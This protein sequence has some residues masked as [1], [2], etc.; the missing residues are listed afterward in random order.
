MKRILLTLVVLAQVLFVSARPTFNI[1]DFGAKGNGKSLNTEAINRAITTCSE[2]GGGVVVVP[3]GEYLCGTIV[4][5]DNV[6]L[7]LEEGSR[8]VATTDLASYKGYVCKR[9]DF[10]RYKMA[11][12]EY[13][14]KAFVL[15]VGKQNFAITG[16][17]T[18]CGQHVEN[19]NGEER[20]RGPH[21]IVFAE[22]KNFTISGIHVDKAGNY[23]FMGYEL[24]NG[25]YDNLRITEGYDGIHIR[26]GKN[27][28]I[29][30]CKIESGDDA[31]AGG[32]WENFVI[33]N[34]DL[35]TTI[36]GVRL[37]YPATGLE[38]G[39]CVFKG[40]GVYPQRSVRSLRG[41]KLMM[42]AVILQ[43]GAWQ[44]C[45]GVLKDI[46]IHDLTIDNLR[47]AFCSDLKSGT[48]AENIVLERIKATNIYHSALQFVGY[49]GGTH[50]SVTLRDVDIEYV[51]RIDD[52]VQNPVVK[53]THIEAHVYPYWGLYLK[54]IK[55]CTLENVKLSYT[56]KECR[57]AIGVE[58]VFKIDMKDV[59]ADDVE[60]KDKLVSINSVLSPTRKSTK[61]IPLR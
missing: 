42:S 48:W 55:F 6:E 61:F 1:K 29:R 57:S 28:T 15:A 59:S 25:L 58:D 14:N 26:G 39:H 19:P 35:N 34:C 52:A 18:I 47:N 53:P 5:Q 24:Q 51:G 32:W 33:T 22:S 13:W 12:A 11:Y 54:G 37:I 50:E 10:E 46:Y 41:K 7:R 38:I 40:P 30:N 8:L 60:G 56:G 36:N 44:D 45:E 31:I 49:W 23:G 21:C 16:E 4:L 2:S 3:K 27:I 9:D 17:G 20:I 43:P